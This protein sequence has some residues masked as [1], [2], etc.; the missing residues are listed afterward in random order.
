MTNLTILNSIIEAVGAN[1]FID[2]LL[3]R[4][5]AEDLVVIVNEIA[6]AHGLDVTMQGGY[7]NDNS[8]AY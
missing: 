5:T 1:T 8:T 6:E 2:E 7:S 3:S 4:M